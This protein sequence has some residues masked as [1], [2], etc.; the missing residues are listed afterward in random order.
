MG[1]QYTRSYIFLFFLLVLTIK[2]NAQ[3]KQLNMPDG[4]QVR[5]LALKG[6]SIYAGTAGGLF[7][8]AN[9][10]KSWDIINNGL[11]NHMIS[12]IAVNG[13]DVFVGTSRGV[14]RSTNNGFSWKHL[15]NGI[16]EN[17]TAASLMCNGSTI[18]AGIISIAYVSTD[19]GDSWKKAT[20]PPPIFGYIGD[21]LMD[22]NTLVGGFCDGGICTS[23]DY[24]VTW[25]PK[26][27]GI[28]SSY[29][30]MNCLLKRNDTIFGGSA[31][32][33]YASGDHCESWKTI[34]TNFPVNKRILSMETIGNILFAGTDG[35]GI[36]ASTDGGKSWLPLKNGIV[37]GAIVWSLQ[38][39]GNLLFAGT[40]QGVYISDDM[41]ASWNLSNKGL[42]A[43]YIE[44]IETF[45]NIIYCG[46]YFSGAFISKDNGSTWTQAKKGISVNADIH[47]FAY[48]GTAVYAATKQ[49]VQKT[50]DGG[51]NW[52]TVNTGLPIGEYNG[53]HAVAAKGKML[54]AS[55]N[56]KGMYQ[57]NDHGA[58]WTK[59]NGFVNDVFTN[60]YTST[61]SLLYAAT[62]SGVYFY[63]EAKDVWEKTGSDPANKYV[64]Q[65][66]VLDNEFY[67]ATIEGIS[68][69]TDNG[70]SWTPANTGIS[71]EMFIHTIY[72]FN[73]RLLIG[74]MA[75]LLF[76][77]DHANSWT[78]IRENLPVCA[79]SD[80]IKIGNNFYVGTGGS[81]IWY[82]P[83][84]EVLS[85]SENGNADVFVV[86]P[87]PGNGVFKIALA[88]NVSDQV[89]QIKII[90]EVGECIY[91]LPHLLTDEINF[92]NQPKGL[93]ILQIISKEGRSESHK[94]I[95]E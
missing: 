44:K 65:L 41:G 40:N 20:V 28:V 18:V 25:T 37:D 53:V 23:H 56:N 22:D 82:K 33:V 70:V 17:G 83:A 88:A 29:C 75:D 68:K 39:K 59:S 16:F 58:S 66:A 62:A 13:N 71:S 32:G 90:N 74:N 43:H 93:Y 42:S 92:S 49:G 94:I 50:L 72:N 31:N 47:S 30:Y 76:S 84:A 91:Q 6:D 2:L 46:T 85:V 77:T 78:S 86:Y 9:D 57:S 45:D 63:N 34:S 11:P 5:C 7:V 24:G 64:N 48:D 67:A 8:S 55:T 52:D 15:T 51:D 10:G 14:Y 73:D 54:F 79:V 3:W 38:T 61:L 89:D 87:N 36:Y 80:M 27:N 95:L 19:N 12:S 35:V 4:G 81:G 60:R 26:N 21:M 1:K 69:S